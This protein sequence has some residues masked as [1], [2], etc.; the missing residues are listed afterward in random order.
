MNRILP[1]LTPTTLATVAVDIYNHEQSPEID[2]FLVD[3]IAEMLN[4][5][6]RDETLSL[7]TAAIGDDFDAAGWLDAVEEITADG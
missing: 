3:V 2:G 6:G 7:L 1:Y 4:N 5:C